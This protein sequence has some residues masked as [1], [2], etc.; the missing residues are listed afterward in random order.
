MDANSF[1]F[2]KPV[3]LLKSLITIVDDKDGLFIDFF[4]GSGT[5]GQAVYEKNIEDGGNRRFLLVQI[6]E[7]L[8]SAS[9]A[10]SS[11][12]KT[13]CDL[14]ERRIAEAGQSLERDNPLALFNNK[15]FRVL[16]LDSSN[17]KNVFYSPE[18]YSPDLLENSETAI[19]PD[20]SSLDLMV[21]VMLELGITLDAEIKSKNLDGCQVYIV[22]D[23]DLICCFDGK[24]NEKDISEIAK[25]QPLTVAFRD[26]SFFDDTISVNCEGIFKQLSPSTKIKIV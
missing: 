24:V 19:K 7:E 8:D 12:M 2:P 18:D 5:L 10:Y 3:S 13:I 22:N 6:P 9:K 4:S 16:K 14:A 17:M 15:G 11:G 1:D 23:N 21:Q 25:L 20:R 26:D